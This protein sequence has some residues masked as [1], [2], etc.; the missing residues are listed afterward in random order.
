M[1]ST[2]PNITNDLHTTTAIPSD[3]DPTS[4]SGTS[5]SESEGEESSEDENE[6]IR[7]ESLTTATDT[8]SI[9]NVS[10]RQ[11][12]RI[13]RIEG[14]SDLMARLS[15][16]LPKMKDANESLEKEIAAGRGQDVMLD[17]VNEADGKDYIEMNLGLGV[18]E[19]KRGDND[20]TSSDESENESPGATPSTARDANKKPKAE[21]DSNVLGK[22]MGENESATDKPSIE[23]IGE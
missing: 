11:K 18:L 4:S 12:P 17:S 8:A 2:E 16:F 9:P 22:L 10:A 14:G 13:Q 6:S 23:E 7:H 3:D 15:A 5:S 1:R 21:E 20:D 19:E